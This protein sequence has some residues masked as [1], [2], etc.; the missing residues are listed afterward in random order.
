M[1]GSGLPPATLATL[2]L[3]Q[4]FSGACGQDFI[5]ELSM[6]RYGAQ[7]HELRKLGYVIHKE[8]CDRHPHI[9]KAW[10]YTLVGV[11]QPDGQVR[12]EVG[13]GR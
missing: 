7:I 8:L 11:P 13:T 10:L 6:A 5:R 2:R 1:I 12:L 9:R 3:L 4:R